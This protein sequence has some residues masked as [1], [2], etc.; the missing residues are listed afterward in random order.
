MEINILVFWVLVPYR[1]IHS[2]ISLQKLPRVSIIFFLKKK[3]VYFSINFL[4]KHVNSLITPLKTLQN[5]N[6]KKSRSGWSYHCILTLKEWSIR[7]LKVRDGPNCLKRIM[8]HSFTSY[9][10]LFKSTH[11]ILKIIIR[12][13]INYYFD[14]SII[15][16]GT[17]ILKYNSD[18]I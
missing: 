8:L 17:L 3:Y 2:D 9:F 16:K 4:T 13:I 5:N 11:V 14:P 12:F 18:F 15:L 6:N 1:S 10:Y 7:S